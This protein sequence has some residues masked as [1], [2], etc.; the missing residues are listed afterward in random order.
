M[1]IQAYLSLLFGKL[2]VFLEDSCIQEQGVAL[3]WACSKGDSSPKFLKATYCWKRLS[4]TSS[5]VGEANREIKE[6]CYK[7]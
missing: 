5:K 4:K 6:E 7:K 1:A 2:E 3:G